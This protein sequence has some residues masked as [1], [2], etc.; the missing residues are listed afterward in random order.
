M[1][2]RLDLLLVARGLAESREKAQAMI[3]AGR[4]EVDGQRVDKAGTP[5]AGDAEV[6]VAAGDAPELEAAR[7]PDLVEFEVAAVARISLVP[8]PDPEG[9]L[10]IADKRGDRPS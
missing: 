1:R 6:R 4:V 2:S 7:P 9:G 5:I 3:L 10:R 8:A